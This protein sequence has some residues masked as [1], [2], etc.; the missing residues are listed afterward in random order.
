MLKK[1][2]TIR[3]VRKLIESGVKYSEACTKVVRS[4]QTIVNWRLK[5]PRVDRYFKK[6][7]FKNDEILVDKIENVFLK[8]LEE[9][10]ASPVEYIFYLTNRRSDN[11][12]RN[13]NVV[14]DQ[15]KH[16]HTY[17]VVKFNDSNSQQRTSSSRV[18][19]IDSPMAT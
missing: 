10:R 15:S 1:A 6:L 7:I 13:D 3:A 14:I 9:D 2:K 11:W 16:K 4:R 8:R 17:N 5:Y 19:G 18:S 12:K